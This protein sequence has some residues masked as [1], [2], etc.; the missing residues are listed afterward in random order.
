MRLR[1]SVGK[2][3][4]IYS[5]TSSARASSDGRHRDPQR[6]C[7]VTLK[8]GRR[9]RRFLLLSLRAAAYLSAYNE[10]AGPAASVT[11]LALSRTS[12]LLAR[13]RL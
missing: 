11:V 10:L 5:I 9:A 1:N 6:P 13:R 7:R 8:H 2:R 12:G 4:G 3:F